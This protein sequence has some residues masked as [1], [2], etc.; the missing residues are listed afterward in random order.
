MNWKRVLKRESRLLLAA[1]KKFYEDH[2]FFLSA[3]ITFNLLIGLIP[4][5][6]ALLS[7]A[8][9][10]L[11]SDQAVLSHI[12]K[13][14]E[15]MLPSFLD[16]EVMN[17]LLTL[18]H[19]RKIA[20][21]LGIGGL[22]WTSTMVFSSLRTALNIV[23]QVE[24]GPGIL[25]GKVID[26]L[27]IFLAGIFHIV[28]MGITSVVTYLHGYH[29]QLFLSMGRIIPFVLS[30]LVPF[31]FTFGMFFLIYKLIPNRRIHFKMAFEAALFT[32]LLWEVTKQLFGW[33]IMGLGRFSL[34]YGSLSALIIFVLWVYYSS[35]ILLL[36]GEV[37]FLLEKE[38]D[39][40]QGQKVSE[41]TRVHWFHRHRK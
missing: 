22:L 28:S 10:Y 37:A 20:G 7:L 3:G 36:G 13:H 40:T 30:Y 21:V 15:D 19:G 14:L 23:F 38:R 12:S 8:G 9:S 16:P 33:Y 27:M 26:L 5:S 1:L 41:K 17:N 32:S 39:R 2:G 29:F 31:L 24:R 25:K 34:I 4:L 6:L 18:I 35:S 11:Y